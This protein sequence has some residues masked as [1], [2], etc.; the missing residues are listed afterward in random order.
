MSPPIRDGSGSSIGSIRLGDGTEIS[1]VRTGAGDVLFSSGPPNSAVYR[2]PVDEGSGQTLTDSIQSESISLNF[3]TWVTGGQ[4][5]G[6]AAIDTDGSDDEGTTASALA[7]IGINQNFSMEVWT[8]PQ[9]L[10]GSSTGALVSQIPSGSNRFQV[11]LDNGGGGDIAGAF[12]NGSSFVATASAPISFNSGLKQIIYTY[13]AATTTGEIYVDSVQGTG[14]KRPNMTG[15]TA[16]AFFVANNAGSQQE[17]DGI[18]DRIQIH[19]EVLSQSQINNLF[20]SHP[21]T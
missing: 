7:E 4:F 18:I 16:D 9:A 10:G 20:Q 14:T 2:W 15:S 6:G 19:D 17:W 21:S 11:G 12:F 1:E 5:D 13:D 8:E 3:S